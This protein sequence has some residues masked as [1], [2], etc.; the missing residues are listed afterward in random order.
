M[1]SELIAQFGPRSLEHLNG[2]LRQTDV[3]QVANMVGLR[4]AK[5]DTSGYTTPLIFPGS[6]T[7][8]TGI[9]VK[10]LVVD[11]G[12]S[13]SDLGKVAVFGVTVKKIVSGS[14]T[15]VIATAGG[16]EQTTSVTLDATAGEAVVGTIAVANA[17]LDSAGVGDVAFLRFR[18]IG[19]STSDTCNGPVVVP[20]VYVY[21]T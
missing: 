17:D 4:V 14:D 7:M 3:V 11:D 1:A 21:N 8:G 20:L 5:S 6:L 16:T 13:A 2:P 19:T 12:N 18:R 15:F 10:F 9:T